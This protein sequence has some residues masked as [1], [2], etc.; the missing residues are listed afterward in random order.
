MKYIK[1]FNDFVN[2]SSS[3][4]IT[5][6]SIKESGSMFGSSY[7]S[8]Y[9][10]DVHRFFSIN[11]SVNGIVGE[12][13]YGIVDSKTVEIISIF[14]ENKFRGEK[15]GKIALNEFIRI[16]KNPKIILKVTSKSKSFWVK[17]GFKPMSG[18]KEYYELN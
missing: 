17:M 12:I 8:I 1:K 11:S 18:S 15:Y 13:E 2:E 16:L 10:D 6:L 5:L 14:I 3:D 9:V 7:Y 4:E